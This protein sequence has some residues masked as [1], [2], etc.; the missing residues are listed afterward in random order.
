MSVLVNVWVKQ[1]GLENPR[2]HTLS[3]VMSRGNE[4]LKE[5]ERPVD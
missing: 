4:V 1:N 2:M 5:V 3:V